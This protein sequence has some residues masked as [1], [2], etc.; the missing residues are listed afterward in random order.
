MKKKNLLSAVCDKLKS[1]LYD[2]L[3]Y[4]SSAQ[5]ALGNRKAL[6]DEIYKSWD[7]DLTKLNFYG[8]LLT[9]LKNNDLKKLKKALEDFE[10]CIEEG[11][12]ALEEVKEKKRYEEKKVNGCVICEVEYIN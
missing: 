5:V 1:G 9:K 10:N 4:L 12:K 7:T 8:E 6:A 2:V 3:S 11:F